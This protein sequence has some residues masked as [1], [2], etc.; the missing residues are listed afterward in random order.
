MNQ[1]AEGV[2]YYSAVL[3]PHRSL[4]RRTTTIVVLMLAGIWFVIGLAF[5]AAGAWPVLPFLGLEVLLL[6]FFFRLN[7]RAGNVS[8]AIN[9]TASAL[10]VRRI[11]PWGKHSLFS[12]P[13]RWLQVNLEPAPGADSWLDNRLELRSHGRSLTIASFLPAHEREA[14]AVALRR[15]LA[16]Q[17]T[18]A[19]P[20][21]P[22][23]TA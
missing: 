8:E 15:A 21:L 5:I 23:S 16:R 12:F 22:I 11:D 20:P 19:P 6:L 7:E 14:V 1:L 2:V 10:T 13:P 4:K 17:H 9:L 3:R 18:A